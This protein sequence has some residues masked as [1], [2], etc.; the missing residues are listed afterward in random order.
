MPRGVTAINGDGV[1]GRGCMTKTIPLNNCG[2]AVR[3][4]EK[5]PLYS[6]SGYSFVYRRMTAEPKWPFPLST[7]IG[8]FHTA[9]ARKQFFPIS[10]RF[11]FKHPSQHLISVYSG[12]VFCLHSHKDFQHQQL[13]HRSR[14]WLMF[15]H[16]FS[17]LE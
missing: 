16:F 17:K 12:R 13:F 9:F 14:I 5:R 2:H 15:R 6:R 10:P 7:A 11:P 8:S 4:G 3:M 1:Q